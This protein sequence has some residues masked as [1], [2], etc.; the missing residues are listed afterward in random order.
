MQHLTGLVV[1]TDLDGTF[2]DHD[3]YS[4]EA[5][6]P[7]LER[8]RENNVPLLAISSKTLAEL[9]GLNDRHHLFAGLIGENGGVLEIG[10]DL[11]QPGPATQTIDDARSAIAKAVSV[12][13]ASFRSSST[14]QIATA[15]GLSLGDAALAGNRNCSDPLIW[16]PTENDITLARNIAGE[17]GLKLVKGGRFHT[18]CGETDKGRAMQTAIA[19]L[20]EQQK[21]PAQRSDITSIALGDSPNDAGMLAQADIAVQIPVKH[22]PVP[23][24]DL[25][26]KSALRAPAPGP[27]G[28]NISINA[29]LDDLS[30]TPTA[31]TKAR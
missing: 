10:G 27:Q 12:P 5:A 9:H 24:L 4:W 19:L 29:I 7:A 31:I 13:V 18:L 26:G 8:L 23:T 11:R 16:Q 17:F 15:T 20:Q 14:D 28:W 21:L 22:G 6:R 3:D 30:Q 25:A 1:F 2:L